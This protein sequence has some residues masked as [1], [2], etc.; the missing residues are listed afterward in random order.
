MWRQ[1][2]AKHYDKEKDIWLIYFRTKRG[3]K[4]EERSDG[5][6]YYRKGYGQE[7][8]LYN[9]AVEEALCYG[10]IDSTVKGIANE[11]YAQLFSPRNPKTSYSQTNKERLKRLISEGKVIMEVLDRLDN[12]EEEKFPIAWDILQSIKKDPEAWKNFQNFP[13]PTN[14]S[15]SVLLKARALDPKS[16]KKD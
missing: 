11:K 2:L 1:W 12:L 10:W 16:S 6:S 7:R 9:D 15:A 4:T 14:A 8:I 5:T 13:T 3:I